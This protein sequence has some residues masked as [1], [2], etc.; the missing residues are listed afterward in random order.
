VLGGLE[1]EIKAEAKVAAREEKEA[2]MKRLEACLDGNDD[3][4]SSSQSAK[5]GS[6]QSSSNINR[7]IVHG[8]QCLEV[9]K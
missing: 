7:D 5:R 2:I 8:T 4:S 9:I 3:R 6:R 1:E